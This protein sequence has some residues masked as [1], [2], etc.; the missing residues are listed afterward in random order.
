M[1]NDANKEYTD[2]E[3][4]KIGNAIAEM[5]HLKKFSNGRYA[6]TWGQKSGQGLYNSLYRV[7]ADETKYLSADA[8]II[9]IK[10]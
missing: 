7:L 3:K 10:Q 4:E 6:T 8:L 2:E 5:L 9:L 1:N